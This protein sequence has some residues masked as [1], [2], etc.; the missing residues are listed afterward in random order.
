MQSC[1][2]YIIYIW[3]LNDFSGG[4]GEIFFQLMLFVIPR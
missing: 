1:Q 2:K 3:F 4:L